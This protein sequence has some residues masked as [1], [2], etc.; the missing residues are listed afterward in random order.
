V[1]FAIVDTG[2]YNEQINALEKQINDLEK[3]FSQVTSNKTKTLSILDFLLPNMSAGFSIFDYEPLQASQG[4]TIYGNDYMAE[5]LWMICYHANV[6][7]RYLLSDKKRTLNMRWPI[8]R[9][10]IFQSIDSVIDP[11]IYGV[12]VVTDGYSTHMNAMLTNKRLPFYWLEI[13]LRL[14]YEK[15]LFFEPLREIK[16]QNPNVPLILV[17]LAQC[18]RVRE[19]TEEEQLIVTD[20]SA[21][22]T[23]ILEIAF[24]AVDEEKRNEI[25]RNPKLDEN[26]ILLDKETEY[27]NIRDGRRITT[28]VPDGALKRVYVFGKEIAYGCGAEDKD[29]LCSILQRKLN[30]AGGEYE[31]VNC[32]W[33]MENSGYLGLEI[34]EKMRS[35]AYQ[36]GDIVVCV[37]WKKIIN[38]AFEKEEY[39]T[40]FVDIMPLVE[41]HHKER[42]IF[43]TLGMVTAAGYTI[44][45]EEIFKA[46][47]KES[48]KY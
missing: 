14:L 9:R 30:N 47:M 20:Y 24:D 48:A 13:I 45:S 35:V 15:N 44:Y 10:L 43:W 19:K 21:N 40:Q 17:D 8:N 31:V 4:I 37:C 36:P 27:V 22:C 26:N 25:I 41:E 18:N 5:L 12:V 34:F 38:E 7:V 23:R 39:C 11:E 1:A 42:P 6:K 16:K 2:K 29:T 33:Y 32:G 46:I 28:D 3:R